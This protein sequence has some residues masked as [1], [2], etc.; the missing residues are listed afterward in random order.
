MSDFKIPPEEI[1]VQIDQIAEFV[2]K[3]GR[4]IE[5]QI[6]E[7]E[8]DNEVFDFLRDKGHE[9]HP[10][11]EVK[12][13]DFAK[14]SGLHVQRKIKQREDPIEK[15]AKAK[16]TLNKENKTQEDLRKQLFKPKNLKPPPSDQFTIHHSELHIID[17][18]IIK[19]TAQFVTR[20]GPKYLQLLTEKQSNNP[21]FD[22][23]K[24]THKLFSYFTSLLDSYSKSFVPKNDYISKLKKYTQNPDSIL[25]N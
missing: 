18:E 23:L 7:K 1:K 8:K 11:Y 5:N 6:L 15:E 9:Y 2:V 19:L 4:H 20:N 14:K 24:H 13:E 10:Y 17:S 3:K 21:Q 16:K 12:L 25:E 22:F